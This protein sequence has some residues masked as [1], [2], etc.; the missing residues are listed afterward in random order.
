MISEDKLNLRKEINAGSEWQ[1]RQILDH[2]NNQSMAQAS[3]V[4]EFVIYKS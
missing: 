2:E 3:L 1:T 4:Q